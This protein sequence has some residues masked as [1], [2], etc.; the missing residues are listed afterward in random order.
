[1]KKSNINELNNELNQKTI[2]NAFSAYFFIFCSWFFLL[3]KTNK[4]INNSFVKSHVKS[5]SLIHF[6][7]IITY[8]IFISNSLFS[9]VNILWF[10]LNHIIAKLLF[11]WLFALLLIWMYK[12][13]NNQ[14]FINNGINLI[15][16]N[17]KL[18]DINNDKSI[19]E[20]DKLT[21]F[22]AYVPFVWFLNYAK[23]KKNKL[24]KIYNK[25]KSCCF[26]DNYI[27]I[28]FWKY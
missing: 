27:F 8:I 26:S 10:A 15:I 22:L 3:N 13:K 5:S 25:T 28:Y 2:N 18:V 20:K 9:W 1:M 6:G 11:L 4:N 21:L 14:V 24:I 16:N 12:A 17:K 19:D 7:F 23:Y